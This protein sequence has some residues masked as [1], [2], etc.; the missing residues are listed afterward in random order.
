V[1]STHKDFFQGQVDSCPAG[2]KLGYPIKRRI[3][4]ER[5]R[6]LALRTYL[7]VEGTTC[8]RID[9]EQ[10]T[11]VTYRSLSLVNYF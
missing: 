10:T 8:T 2:W 9:L 3:R 7:W 11:A 6:E 1:A 5:E 4:R